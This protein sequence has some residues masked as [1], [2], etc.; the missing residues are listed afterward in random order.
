MSTPFPNDDMVMGN[1]LNDHRPFSGHAVHTVEHLRVLLW[2]AAVTGRDD[3]KLAASKA[4]HKLR[5]YMLPNSAV[6]GDEAIHGF[7]RPDIGY[8]YCTTTE[9][10]F[11]L[12]HSLS[13]ELGAWPGDSIERLVFNAAQGA[14][15]ANGKGIAYLATDTRL[16]ATSAQY[17][18]YG[19]L[20]NMAGR[21][22]YSP[23]H[24]DVACCCNPNSVRL[25]PH[26]VSSLWR[27]SEDG[28]AAVTYGACSVDTTVAGIAVHIEEDT[29]Y[30]FSDEIAIAITPTKPVQFTIRLRR[31]TWAR[32]MNVTVGGAQPQV[33]EE[34]IVIRKLWHAGDVI[35]VQMNLTVRLVP[36]LTGEFA[37][38]WGALQFAQPFDY[39][40]VPIK[41]Y[42]LE[43]FH[44]YDVFPNCAT[45]VYELLLLDGTQD[46]YGLRLEYSPEAN[47]LRPWHAAPLRLAAGDQN[48]IPLGCTL[49]RRAAFPVLSPRSGQPAEP[50]GR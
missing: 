28:L 46:H 49:L 15:L 10:A 45:Q 20:V 48:L 22:K 13:L 36:Y 25:L 2:A 6:I 8:E 9:L 5:H 34:Y 17:D 21:F 33:E 42:P 4:L 27:Q 3:L 1:L 14:R 23:T 7:P 26:Y 47:K 44:D 39:Q 50:P 19:F 24:E 12:M 35:Q 30:P 32:E 11:S 37:V 16:S 40:M 29:D 31:P 41:L 38:F 43:G 18:S